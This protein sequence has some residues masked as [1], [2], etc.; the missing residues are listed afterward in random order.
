MCGIVGY[1]GNRKVI[2][3]LLEGLRRLEYRGYD[4]AG[5]VYQ[6]QDALVKF[7]AA[8]KLVH[9]EQTVDEHIGEEAYTGLGHTRWATHGAPTQ[10]NAHPHSDCT[11]ELVVVH[12]GIIENYG[13]LK[14]ELVADG[15]RFSS[16]TDTEVLAHLIEKY[17][18]DDLVTAVRKALAR[19]E[20]SY[21]L[22]VMW[23]K[24]PGR[25]VA[26]RNQ[27]PLVMGV[28]TDACYLASDI[29]ALLPYTKKVIFLDDHELAVLEK[30]VYT[31]M[32]VES[33]QEISKE[34]KTIHWNAAMAE[35]AGY[36][37]F[38]LK[39]IYYQSPLHHQQ[40]IHL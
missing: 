18:K 8:G 6:Y 4:S 32:G 12:N 20:G 29:P 17:L 15:H 26:A 34:I 38:M 14:Q 9:L 3:V 24:D 30:G 1:T 35:K 5:L 7:R 16:E 28:D 21:A 33:G 36:K 37:H 10:D 22:G 39:D 23:L 19:V 11:G 25:L 40:Q 27:S 31:I 2:P 13:Q